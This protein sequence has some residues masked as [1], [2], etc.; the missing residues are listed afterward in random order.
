[1][2]FTNFEIQ[3][4]LLYRPPYVFTLDLDIFAG[5]LMWRFLRLHIFHQPLHFPRLL[6]LEQITATSK[7]DQV[8]LEF[9]WNALYSLSEISCANPPPPPEQNYISTFTSLSSCY[10]IQSNTAVRN[11]QK[12][13]RI[14]NK[15]KSF[16]K[17]VGIILES[18]DFLSDLIN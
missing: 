5:L 2:I 12:V 6:P 8:L 18:F 10:L 11:L 7:A 1:M 9:L 4:T 14:E 13:Q 3:R 15:L 16:G 17:G